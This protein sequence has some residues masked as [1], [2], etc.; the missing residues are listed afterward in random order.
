MD[1]VQAGTLHAITYQSAEA[2]GAAAMQLAVDWFSGKTIPA[3]RYLPIRI[4][5]KDNV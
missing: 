4:I 5:A 2:E 1:Y 3:V